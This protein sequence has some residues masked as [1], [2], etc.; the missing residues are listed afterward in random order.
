[1]IDQEVEASFILGTEMESRDACAR[2]KICNA[3]MGRT[4]LVGRFTSQ[5]DTQPLLVARQ[6]QSFVS[7]FMKP[8]G[9]II[10]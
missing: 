6:T 7:C 9:E 5:S 10:G 1:M 4:G 3:E 8:F 2:C